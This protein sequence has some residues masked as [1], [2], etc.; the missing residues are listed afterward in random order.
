MA[1]ARLT[2]DAIAAAGAALLGERDGFTLAR[3]GERLGVDPTAVYRHFRDKDEL[4]RAAGDRLLAPV[5]ARLPADASWRE[6]V[7]TICSRLRRVHLAHPGLAALVRTGPPMQANEFALTERL[8]GALGAAGLTDDA[9]CLAYH[10]LIGLT[11]GSAA[12]DAPLAQLR[13]AERAAAYR[14]FGAAYAALDPAS[15]PRSV[16]LAERLWTGTAQDRFAHAL[17]RLLDGLAAQ[18]PG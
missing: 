17:D 10:A 15:H 1:R 14:G 9:A 18:V 3:L 4:V 7:V 12:L 8:L 6:V 5:V 13:P 2:K 16:A 11:I